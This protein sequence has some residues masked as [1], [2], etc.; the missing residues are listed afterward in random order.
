MR[1][2]VALKPFLAASELTGNVEFVSLFVFPAILGLTPAIRFSPATQVDTVCEGMIEQRQDVSPVWS[3]A[4]DR[5][6]PLALDKFIEQT[7]LSAVTV[8]R[9]RKKGFL[10]TVNICGR[11]YILRTEIA[12]FNRRA[13]AGEFAQKYQQPNSNTDRDRH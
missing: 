7:G 1:S 9:Y 13:Q 5:D 4:E 10:A 12:R 6:P 8:W 11:H 3:V 2:I